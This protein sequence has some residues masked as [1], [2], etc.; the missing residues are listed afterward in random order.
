M[1]CSVAIISDD[2]LKIAGLKYI[3]TDFFGITP[4]IAAKSDFSGLE[5]Y[6]LFLVDSDVFS[7]NL[8]FFIPRRLKTLIMTNTSDI[9]ADNCIRCNEAFDNIIKLIGERIEQSRQI[10]GNNGGALSSRETDVLKLV[11]SG[12]ANKEIADRLNISINTVL[13]HRKNISAKLGIKS[14]SGLSLFAIMNGLIS[15]LQ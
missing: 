11:A 3:L 10:Q 8:E 1:S 14:V 9:V 2:T 12:F 6:D 13:S 7:A 15:P 4:V 5:L